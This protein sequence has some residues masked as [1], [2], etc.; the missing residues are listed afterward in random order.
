MQN[1]H[2]DIAIVGGG[3]SGVYSAWQLK[4]QFPGSSIALFEGSERIGGRLLSVR[5]PGVDNMV[6]ELG[7]M[8]ILDAQRQPLI[9][10]LLKQIN[11][12]AS[13]TQ[14]IELYPF[15]VDTPVNL[16]YLR[17]VRLRLQDY[18]SNP[19]ALPYNYSFA[20]FAQTPGTVMIDAIEEIVPGITAA[21]LTERERREMAQRA[22]F[23]GK[24]LYEQGF[25]NVLQQVLTNEDYHYC[26]DAGGYDS[27]MSNWNAA[28]AIPWFL[29]DFGD[30]VSYHGF[31]LGF[32]QV[33]LALAK[34]FSALNGELHMGH[35]LMGFSQ[36]DGR[37]ELNFSCNGTERQC[38]ATHLV[39]AMPRR[40]LDLL[41]NTCPLLQL[42][43]VK[44]LTS[45]VTPRP[46]FKLF[47][48]YQQPWWVEQSGI[49]AG[50]S[51]TDLP[52]RQTYYWPT[53]EGKPALSG[54]AI[55]MASYDDGVNVGFWD[56]YRQK[57]GLAWRQQLETLPLSD[58]QAFSAVKCNRQDIDPQWRAHQAPAGMVTEV[59]RQ[60]NLMH[61]VSPSEEANSQPTQAAFRD[62]GDDPYG[63]GWN[64]WNIGVQSNLVKHK[65]V[66]PLE[67]AR[68]FI[69]GEAYSDGQGWVE[70]ALQTADLMLARLMKQL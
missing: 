11:E 44:Q 29:T 36:E 58:A 41:E 32:Q 56:G 28:D 66:Q 9:N 48:A 53:S 64:S 22:E 27:T 35:K 10:A 45:S 65:I 43:E 40:S 38:S 51:V 34:E 18:Q 68:L 17:E 20:A 21:H 47:T 33:P 55:L 50:R 31:K 52:V 25:W 26:L 57:R 16:A 39:L 4:K 3:M 1:N 14:P 61:D 2:F 8:R 46:L 67:H 42:P 6:A 24:M 70:G 63:G 59:T 13:L 30:D 62:W 7:G 37:F 49:E 54:P 19:Y 23:Q 69:C 12:F 5:A 60:L 15:P